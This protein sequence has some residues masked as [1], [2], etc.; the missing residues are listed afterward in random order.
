MITDSYFTIG[1]SH[2]ICQ[3][4]ATHQPEI[5][6]L[7]DGCSSVKNSDIGSRLLVFQTLKFFNANNYVEPSDIKTIIQSVVDIA[8]DLGINL[9]CIHATLLLAY[10]I[11]N[12]IK[13]ICC[14]DGHITTKKN[15]VIMDCKIAYKNS[16]PSHF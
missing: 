11:E 12:I 8:C 1:S 4:Y 9:D 15:N 5:I 13:V 3:D 7:S 2:E 10:K 14:G 16:M 6:I